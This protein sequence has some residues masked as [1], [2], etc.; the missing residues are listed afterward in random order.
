[1]PSIVIT[2]GYDAGSSFALSEGDNLIGRNPECLI[3]LSDPWISRLHAKLAVDGDKYRIFDLQSHNGTSVNGEKISKKRVSHGDVIMFG[4]TASKFL[5]DEL[6]GVAKEH[7]SSLL[8]AQDTVLRNIKELQAELTGPQSEPGREQ[9]QPSPVSPV[10][11]QMRVMN[12]IGKVLTH[13]FDQDTALKSIIDLVMA[14]VRGRR[15]FLLLLDKDG[16]LQPRISRQKDEDKSPELEISR[17]IINTALNERVGILTVNA[18]EDIRFK[19]SKSIIAHA[20]TSCI[21]APLWLE[22][23]VL[24]VVVIDSNILEHAFGE[25]DLDILTAVGYQIALAIEEY[26]LRERIRE[27]EDKRHALLRH[28]SRDVASLLMSS[29]ELEKDPLEVGLR[30]ATVLFSDIEGFTSVSEKLSP[31]EMADLLNGY[32]KLMSEAIFAED[33]TL[34]KFIGDGI[35]AIFGAPYSHDDDPARAIRCALRMYRQLARYNQKL[36]EHLRIKARIGIN[37]GTVVAGNFGSMQRMEYS[38]LGDVVNV[39]SR[40]QSIAGTGKILIGKNT[41]EKCRGMFF[42]RPLGKKPVKG[43]AQEVEVYEVMQSLPEDRSGIIQ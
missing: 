35:M 28:F 3:K 30:E 8:L 34:D 21:C 1:M 9:P 24:G 14:N 37:T 27:E 12:E 4:K 23:R 41:F 2:S 18:Q 17:T 13:G 10:R 19:E 22:D 25:E 31:L 20:I 40:L 7:S 16:T 6:D 36:P 11:R 39:A 42:F 5:A 29:A 38:V 43:K 32:F 33:G 15:G 26:R